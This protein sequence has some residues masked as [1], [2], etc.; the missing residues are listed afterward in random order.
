MIYINEGSF[1]RVVAVG[2]KAYKIHQTTKLR[3]ME[4]WFGH[5]LKNSQNILRSFKIPGL[6]ISSSSLYNATLEELFIRRYTI[7]DALFILSGLRKAF[8]WLLYHKVCHTDCSP[9]N[10]LIRFD[11]KREGGG[12]IRPAIRTLVKKVVLA[13]FSSAIDIRHNQSAREDIF[14]KNTIVFSR[15]TTGFYPP[16]FLDGVL[17]TY[18]KYDI[19][20]LDSWSFGI[21][22]GLCLHYCEN[23]RGRYHSL[24]SRIK[25]IPSI[26]ERKNALWTD[27]YILKE[28]TIKFQDFFHKNL[29][30]IE[31]RN[32]VE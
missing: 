17:V 22:C 13:D 32:F 6:Y 25:D 26:V 31:Q 30:P 4:V 1:G 10:V 27:I 9:S 7:D 8:R 20:K 5:I 18:T 12:L 16:E 11:L 19:F 23:Q 2:N 24:I 14:T 15:P 3:D 21:L 29:L 28:E